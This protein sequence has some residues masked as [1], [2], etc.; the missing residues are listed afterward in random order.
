MNLTSCEGASLA[1]GIGSTFLG[2]NGPVNDTVCLENGLGGLVVE[3][4]GGL[5]PEDVSWSLTLP[6]GSVKTGVAGSLE[7]GTCVSPYP[8]PHPSVTAIPTAEPSVS[9]MPTMLCELYSI[10]LN[11]VFGDGYALMPPAFVSFCFISVSLF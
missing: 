5:Y 7:I 11:D 8:S 3:V 9:N 2:G 4:G 1:T 10:E 6:S